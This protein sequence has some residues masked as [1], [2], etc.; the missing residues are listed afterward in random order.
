M[1]NSNNTEVKILDYIQ[2]NTQATPKE[3]AESI[4]VSPQMIHRTLR[5]LVDESI[6]EKIGTA[7]QVHY[8]H[9]S[10]TFKVLSDLSQ[11]FDID[12]KRIIEENFYTITPDG[13]ELFGMKAFTTWCAQRKYDVTKKA[14]EYVEMYKKY[15]SGNTE[16]TGLDATSKIQS[17]FTKENIFLDTLIYLYPYSLPVFGKTKISEMLFHAK[18]NQDAQLMKRV[19][20]MIHNKLMTVIEHIKPDAIG[21]IPPTLTRKKQLMKELQSF[22]KIG[23]PL[24]SIQKIKTPITIQQKSLKNI[25]DRII[26]A[27]HT[28]IVS[29]TKS[30]YKKILLIDDF[31]GSG[32]TLNQ[33]AKKCKQQKVADVV[34]GLTLTGSVNGFEVIREI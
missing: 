2:A 13:K 29:N 10:K 31:T 20:E 1:K 7:P 34:V 3:M 21:F 12:E 27:E 17:S 11:N 14:E 16:K 28:M 32:A 4:G 5:K 18:Q 22:L 9:I 19:F 8:R 26:N 23:I 24:I 6:I 33:I 15:N 25:D 30:T